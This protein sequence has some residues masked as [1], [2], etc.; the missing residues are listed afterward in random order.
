MKPKA[1]SLKRSINDKPLATLTTTKTQITK[2][3]NERCNI[4]TNLT[5]IKKYYKGTL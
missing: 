5:E 1:S 3:R 2:I 4:I